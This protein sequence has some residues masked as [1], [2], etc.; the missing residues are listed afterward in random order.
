FAAN[1]DLEP[2]ALVGAQLLGQHDRRAVDDRN[3]SD[4]QSG[5]FDS[6]HDS[7]PLHSQTRRRPARPAEIPTA[8]DAVVRPGPTLVR[9]LKQERTHLQVHASDEAGS[10]PA[11]A[12]HLDP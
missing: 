8:Q 3:E 10:M 12:R 1:L 4:L 7:L 6:G 2:V 11:G 9:T 5:S